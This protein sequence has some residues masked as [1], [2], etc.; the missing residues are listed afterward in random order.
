MPILLCWG[1]LACGETGILAA[2]GEILIR[3][4]AFSAGTNQKGEQELRET[5]TDEEVKKL[6]Q[7]V[8]ATSDAVGIPQENFEINPAEEFGKAIDK[9]LGEQNPI[10]E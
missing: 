7:T 6:L 1:Q 4:S 3:V 10:S 9:A 2:I 8:K 5:L